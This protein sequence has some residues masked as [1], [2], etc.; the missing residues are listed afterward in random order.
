MSL[1]RKTRLARLMGLKTRE[2]RHFEQLKAKRSYANARREAFLTKPREAA[3]PAYPE[4]A[5]VFG[6]EEEALTFYSELLSA[7]P[8]TTGSESRNALRAKAIA[9]EA[10]RAL[11][12]ETPVSP[13]KPEGRQEEAHLII[14]EE[15]QTLRRGLRRD[16][17]AV[18]AA[19]PDTNREAQARFLA[20]SLA[21]FADEKK[22]L[23]QHPELTPLLTVKKQAKRAFSQ[24]VV[25]DLVDKAIKD[26]LSRAI[27]DIA[28]GLPLPNAEELSL[29]AKRLRTSFIG[30]QQAFPSALKKEKKPYQYKGV[31]YL[32]DLLGKNGVKQGFWPYS[33]DLLQE[34]ARIEA[35][36]SHLRNEQR[37]AAFNA[38]PKEDALTLFPELNPLYEKFESACRFY[39]EKVPTEV[40][41]KAAH[42]LVAPDFKRIAQ[43]E[44]LEAVSEVT[45]S[46]HEALLAKALKR[47]AR[48]KE[49]SAGLTEGLARFKR[50]QA[51]LIST[52]LPEAA[53]EEGLQSLASA[54]EGWPVPEASAVS[55]LAAN[56]AKVSSKDLSEDLNA[57]VEQPAADELAA[58]AFEDEPPPVTDETKGAAFIDLESL[59]ATAAALDLDALL[60]GS[61]KTAVQTMETDAKQWD[62]NA[63][64]AG[65]KS[66]CEALVTALLG[67]P[68]L[69]DKNQLRFGSNKGSLIVT[70]KG[71]KQGLWFDHQTG[72]G[73][74]LLQ[75]IQQE[76]QL[77]FKQALDFAGDFLKLSPEPAFKTQIDLSDM[78][79]L[80]ESR[81]KSLRY[82]RELANASLPLKGSLGEV[83]LAKTR[84]IDTS[85]CSDSIRFLPALREPDSGQLHPA[86]LLVG[87]NLNGRVQ[88]VQAIFLDSTGKKL[89][90]PNPKRS[91]GLIKGAAVVLS[92]GESGLYG[93]AEGAETGLS[94]AT[95]F[96]D[97]TI[98]AALGSIT[99]VSAMPFEASGNT[100][101]VFSDHDSPDNKSVKKGVNHAADEL[102]AKGFNVLIAKPG[103]PGKDFNDVL[104]EQGIDGVKAQA[105]TL[106]LYSPEAPQHP[107][108]PAHSLNRQRTKKKVLE[109]E[110]DF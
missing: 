31:N 49:K 84:G 46:V 30:L 69:H 32:R 25:P 102:V 44:V 43:G 6:V 99:N 104:C 90:C 28:R 72:V 81:Q 60:Q 1:S 24:W 77:S 82:A 107:N 74:N 17:K 58:L 38:L 36:D 94:V 59:R 100:F 56:E 57:P 109:Q 15:C 80:D 96:K 78:P 53:N 91:Y 55:K 61:V 27:K 86:L 29:E 10:L 95:A 75:L 67:E 97:L 88:G 66:Q 50:F 87:K 63:I 19:N 3:E 106:S 105:R 2:Y 13:F 85:R 11:D 103:R 14:G 23:A 64:T 40:A 21:F 68:L 22:A 98:L 73:G 54:N 4:L 76:K 45:T 79:H 108:L 37:E 71:E 5:A 18:A 92:I 16:F 70:I 42:L 20:L 47:P 101:I 7:L 26:C 8:H 65:L 93:L 52:A 39:G 34:T 12:R 41:L 48:F 89:A 83:Y 33:P 51:A 9:I 62:I 110:L 35:I